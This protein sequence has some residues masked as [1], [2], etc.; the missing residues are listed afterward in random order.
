MTLIS[1]EAAVKG[2]PIF[3][4]YSLMFLVYPLNPDNRQFH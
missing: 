1:V 2:L 4:K 3:L